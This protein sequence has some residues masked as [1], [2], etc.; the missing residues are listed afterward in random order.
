MILRARMVLPLRGPALENG[1]VVVRGRR[2][3]AVSPWR[4]VSAA[5]RKQVIDL[6]ETVVL[7]GLI[8]AHCHLDYTHMAGHFPPPRRFADWLKQI[9]STK[10]GWTLPDY[11]DS[12]RTGAQMLLRTGTTTVADIEA[13][14]Q[15]L[16]QVW[17][18][19]PL[20]VF[21]LL[22]MIGITNRR[23]P[24]AI[25]GEAIDRIA[26]LKHPRC[27]AGLSPHAPYST[28]PELL[29]RSATV[30]RRRHWLV[31]THLAES[32]LELAMFAQRK[33]ELF[34]W[35]QRSGR[36]MADCGLGSP[37]QH[38]DHCGLLGP[39]LLA[40]HVNYLARGDAALL[41]KR[42]VSVVHC[43]RSH[44]Y[45]RHDPFP[46]GRLAG[47]GVNV[48]LGTDSLA[49]VCKN[50]PHAQEL[51]LFAEMRALA[52]REKALSPPAILRMATIH[53][54]RALGMEEQLGELARGAFADL[55]VLPMTRKSSRVHDAV[56]EQ[57]G[58]VA[59]SMIQGQW[60]I[61]PSMVGRE[62]SSVAQR[63]R[64]A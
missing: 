15:L 43:P 35:L 8:N 52:D 21:S 27:R 60:A 13:V 5:T 64:R 6:G 24:E 47:A 20:R 59:A 31:C 46:L 49:S 18:T 37:V 34:E 22:E 2:I 33:G 7:P 17:E 3:Q 53:G 48:C 44:F 38:L 19:T 39:N 51:N 4:D 32:A 25:L 57:E 41:G 11:T 30:A 40:A 63:D 42:G 36:D 12:W 9:T 62:K 54:A 10:A 16:P 1:A 50:L 55:I 29:R 58:P 61:R 28:V 56:L 14:P 45:F 23:T 26:R